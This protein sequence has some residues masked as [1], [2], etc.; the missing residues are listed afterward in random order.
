[1]EI[2]GLARCEGTGERERTRTGRVIAS[3]TSAAV[4]APTFVSTAAA[5]IALRYCT[6]SFA[7]SQ[8]G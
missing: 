8:P 4:A 3:A 1:M 2:S 7:I 6:C 5:S